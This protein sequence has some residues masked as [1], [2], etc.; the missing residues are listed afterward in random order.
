M[1]KINTQ[2]I[3]V[4]LKNLTFEK[5][6]MIFHFISYREKSAKDHKQVIFYVLTLS[7]VAERGSASGECFFNSQ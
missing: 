7:P 4:T 1:Q 6:T 5:C 3:N 2:K